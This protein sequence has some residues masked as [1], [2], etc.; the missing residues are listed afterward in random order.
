MLRWN[1]QNGIVTI[2]KSVNPVR[3]IENSQI[4]D[5]ELDAA[6]MQAIDQLDKGQRV[7]P[8]PDVFC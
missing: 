6:D 3:I 8:D 4:F 1:V 5:F 7:G 2:P